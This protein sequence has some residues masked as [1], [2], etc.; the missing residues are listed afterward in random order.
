[1]SDCSSV[2]LCNPGILLATI[3]T[4]GANLIYLTVLN[5]LSVFKYKVRGFTLTLLI[6]IEAVMVSVLIQAILLIQI[7]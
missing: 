6:G 1:M 2:V 3:L 5:I 4:Y 7:K